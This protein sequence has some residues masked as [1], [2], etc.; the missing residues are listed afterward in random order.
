MNTINLTLVISAILF[1][2]KP[3]VAMEGVDTLETPSSSSGQQILPHEKEISIDPLDLSTISI[4]KTTDPTPKRKVSKT[5]PLN[6]RKSSGS[7][8]VGGINS[9]KFVLL[10]QMAPLLED[11]RKDLGE[12]KEF[13]SSALDEQYGSPRCLIIVPQEKKIKSPR[14]GFKRYSL[15]GPIDFLGS[16]SNSS[17][18]EQKNFPKYCSNEPQEEKN[19]FP[20]DQ[21]AIRQSRSQV[22]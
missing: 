6:R 21:S 18:G 7:P 13:S 2:T 19:E 11:Q 4:E 3:V 22:F 14:P 1:T 10:H 8:R 9:P 12:T 20:R 5:L 16:S 15:E 17:Q